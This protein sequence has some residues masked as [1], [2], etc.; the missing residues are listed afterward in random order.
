MN[1]I[2]TI[3]VACAA[4]STAACQSTSQAAQQLFTPDHFDP[5][6]LYGGGSDANPS[7]LIIGTGDK[8]RLNTGHP[9][10][11]AF[12]QSAAM[13]DDAFVQV[14]YSYLTVADQLCRD[15]VADLTQARV[16][17]NSGF[18]ML[19]TLSAVTGSA[20]SSSNGAN[21][22]AGPRRNR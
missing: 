3:I 13:D 8:A 4:L 20:L 11:F 5:P 17:S 21:A 15:R 16:A 2:H 1:R 14:A 6:T 9:N 19:T 7:S 18:G 22:A 12:Q 10:V